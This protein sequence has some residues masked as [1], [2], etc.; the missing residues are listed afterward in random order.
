MSDDQLGAI[1]IKRLS[2][3]AIRVK[4]LARQTEFYTSSL[5]LEMVDQSS[6]R[7]YL[8]ARESH[9]H[10]VELLTQQNGANHASFEVADDAELDRAKAI[11]FRQGSP[12]LVGPAADIEPG[13]RR[14]LRFKDPEEN[15]IE[16]VSTV[17]EI[18]SGYPE[19]PV[20]PLSLNHAVLFAGP[21]QTT[22]FL[23]NC[24]GDARHRYGPGINDLSPMQSKPS[25]T[26]FYSTT[27]TR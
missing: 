12:I 24:P 15:L 11:L 13:I 18:S 4:D 1:R 21:G 8:R 9:H 14:L 26:R 22:E 7:C 25:F 20:K 2:H 6:G 5:G 17:S 19:K 27:S 10:V 23:S 16:L 3:A